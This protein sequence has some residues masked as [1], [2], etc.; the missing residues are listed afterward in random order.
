MASSYSISSSWRPKLDEK[1][2]EFTEPCSK[3]SR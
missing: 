2:D 3:L 1:E